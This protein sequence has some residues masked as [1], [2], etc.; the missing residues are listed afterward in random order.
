MNDNVNFPNLKASTK[1]FDSY[2]PSGAGKE[3]DK[4]QESEKSNFYSRYSLYQLALHP[5]RLL[6]CHGFFFPWQN[7]DSPVL[8]TGE[9]M[10]QKSLIQAHH[11]LSSEQVLMRRKQREHEDVTGSIRDECVG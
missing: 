9:L 10:I 2:M 8:T 4:C 7:A 6:L 5:R 11:N 1:S 3:V